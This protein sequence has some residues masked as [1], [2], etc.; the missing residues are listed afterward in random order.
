[1]SVRSLSPE[2]RA[3]LFLLDLLDNDPAIVAEY[4]RLLRKLKDSFGQSDHENSIEDH[5]S[6]LESHGLPEYKLGWVEEKA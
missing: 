3:V 5:N 1:M 4:K 6:W 2:L